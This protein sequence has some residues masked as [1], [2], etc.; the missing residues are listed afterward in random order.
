MPADPGWRPTFSCS[1]RSAP[2]SGV[3]PSRETTGRR[4]T[5]GLPG[6]LS[7]QLSA[8]RS[9]LV[10]ESGPLV[11]YCDGFG[12]AGAVT[13]GGATVVVGAAGVEGVVAGV[14]GFTRFL[15]NRLSRFIVST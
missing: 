8:I 3:T 10:T 6:S 9:L 7:S 2:G 11:T 15:P 4:H 1:R 13:G 12:D 14:A 5:P